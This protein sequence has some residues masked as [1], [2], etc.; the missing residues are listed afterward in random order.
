MVMILL[1]AFLA[2]GFIALFLIYAS[3]SFLMFKK[4][5]SKS[6]FDDTISHI[7]AEVEGLG[8]KVPHVHDLQGVMKKFGK[9]IRRTTVVE[10][11]KPEIAYPILKNDD[12]RLVSVLMPCRISVYQATNGEVFVVRMKSGVLGKLFGGVISSAMRQADR[13]TAIIIRNALARL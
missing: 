6:N 10:I 1:A 13:E 2:G 4:S 5:I 3:S 11:C 7:L 9:E 8:W 12:T